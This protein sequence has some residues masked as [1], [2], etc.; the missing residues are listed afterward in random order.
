MEVLISIIVPVYNVPEEFLNE[1]IISI[2]KQ[3]LKN[4]EIILVDDG[5]TDNSVVICDTYAQLDNRIRVIHKMNGGLTSARKAGIMAAK[6]KW[7]TFVDGD[8]WIEPIMCE[9]ICQ[10]S[11]NNNVD[12]IMF[13]VIKDY[14]KF[15]FKCNYDEFD[16]MKVFEDIE[17]RNLQVKILNYNSNIATSYAKLIRRSFILE[18]NI[19]PNESI[20]QGG[21]DVEYNLRLFDKVNKVLMYKKYLYHYRYN[22]KSISTSPNEYN[23][24]RVLNTFKV[25]KNFIDSKENNIALLRSFYNRLSY[26]LVTTA[27]TGYFNPTFNDTY[28]VKVEKFKK[29][30]NT[31][32]IFD[33]LQQA[34]NENM[35]FGRK[36]VLLCTKK[37]LF[38]VINILGKIRYL[39]KIS[40]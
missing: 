25:I 37:K 5:S 2:I 27:I 15:K 20:R 22:G 11:L 12:V 18:H 21:E 6:G 13:G 19:L 33:S 36:I 38:I 35:S 40:M 14:Q 9:E 39:Q 29:Y 17:C 26:V 7:I 10:V 1:C 3:T 23:F 31:D 28:K 4:I 34:N 24:Y 8:D 16:D 30:L 32:I